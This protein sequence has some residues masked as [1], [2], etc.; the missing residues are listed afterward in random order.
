MSSVN[1]IVGKVSHT[2]RAKLYNKFKPTTTT[3]TILPPPTTT[4]HNTRPT[5]FTTTTTAT[6]ALG[7]ATAI[8]TSPSTQ[9]NN[10]NGETPPPP[11]QQQ[12]KEKAKFDPNANYAQLFREQQRKLPGYPLFDEDY[13]ERHVDMDGILPEHPE[14]AFLSYI[15]A[16]DDVDD[17][18]QN[19][20]LYTIPDTSFLHDPDA[21][22]ISDIERKHLLPPLDPITIPYDPFEDSDRV[23]RSP[24]EY[25]PEET[26]AEDA[27]HLY[28]PFERPS[29]ILDDDF[30]IKQKKRKIAKAILPVLEERL[31]TDTT[32]PTKA[33][34]MLT[35]LQYKK[36]LSDEEKAKKKGELVV[37]DERP[38]QFAPKTQE[39][40]NKLYRY[41]RFNVNTER[42]DVWVLSALKRKG[43]LGG[44]HPVVE[45]AQESFLLDELPLPITTHMRHHRVVPENYVW[46]SAMVPILFN[47][48][49]EKGS[50]QEFQINLVQSP[51]QNLLKYAIFI[52]KERYKMTRTVESIQE[53]QHQLVHNVGELT[54]QL[55]TYKEASDNKWL[56]PKIRPIYDSLRF[57]MASACDIHRTYR[58]AMDASQMYLIQTQQECQKDDFGQAHR[59][60]EEHAI[61][62]L[63]LNNKLHQLAVYLDNQINDFEDYYNGLLVADLFQ[64]A[65]NGAIEAQRPRLEEKLKNINFPEPP[66][67]KVDSVKFVNE[68][69]QYSAQLNTEY[70]HQALKSAPYHH[71]EHRQVN[72]TK[73]P[74][75]R[76]KRKQH[77]G[78]YLTPMERTLRHENNMVMISQKVDGLAPVIEPVLLKRAQQ[79]KEIIKHDLAMRLEKE[80]LAESKASVEKQLAAN[81]DRTQSGAKSGEIEDTTRFS[82]NERKMREFNDKQRSKMYNTTAPTQDDPGSKPRPVGNLEL[83]RKLVEDDAKNDYFDRMVS[84]FDVP[85]DDDYDWDGEYDEDDEWYEDG[86][87]EEE[88]DPNAFYKGGFSAYLPQRKRDE[89]QKRDEQRQKERQQKKLEDQQKRKDQAKS[90][91]WG[92]D[93]EDVPVKRNVQRGGLV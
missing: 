64:T 75:D 31:K 25:Y 53:M 51:I 14:T 54:K 86:D 70:A 41:V 89:I 33:R 83:V 92:G 79:H 76:R 84:E 15:T 56:H 7:G 22:V 16:L 11:Q 81:V 5:A 28:V 93:G 91:S 35:T 50:K 49:N 40:K 2:T 85:D 30:L 38:K 9:D 59:V 73:E 23:V 44:L 55:W 45:Q 1:R 36:M 46:C 26:D 65:K 71:V 32:N 4:P 24:R 68:L 48:S 19:V 62:L 12:R 21:P 72:F 27:A 43:L 87:D 17:A 82:E 8:T 18:T 63:A 78:R 6:T 58:P 3:T 57:S 37:S 61:L 47:F 69:T 10:N 34:S 74:D 67:L 60:V 90:F 66:I 20:P 29:D 80:R 77:I 42:F 13:S 88:E 52:E 39:E